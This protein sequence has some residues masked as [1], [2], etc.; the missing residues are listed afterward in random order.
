MVKLTP[1]ELMR[2]SE[3]KKLSDVGAA[4]KE[5]YDDWFVL[6]VRQCGRKKRHGM[7]DDGNFDLSFDEVA[8]QI[9]ETGITNVA[10]NLLYPPSATD[11][12]FNAEVLLHQGGEIRLAKVVKRILNSGG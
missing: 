5:C 11:T 7:K 6:S 3:V 8:P 9:P 12:L 2:E 1:D 10:G 4:I